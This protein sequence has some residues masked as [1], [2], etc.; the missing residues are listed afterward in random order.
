[1][2]STGAP[3]ARADFTWTVVGSQIY[4]WG[5]IGNSGQLS[6][7][8]VYDPSSNSWQTLLTT[9]SPGTRQFGSSQYTGPQTAAAIGNAFYVFGGF[10]GSTD[11][12]AGKCYSLGVL[13]APAITSLSPTTGSTLGGTSVAVNGSNFVSGATVTFDTTAVTASFVSSTQLTCTTPSHAAGAVNVTVTNPDTQTSTLSGGF[14]YISPPTISNIS[15]TSGSTTGGTSVTITGT[16]FQ[17]N[18][19][20]TFAGLAGTSGSADGD[21]SSA[22]FNGPCHICADSSGNLYV[23]DQSNNTIRMVTPSGQVSTIA[24]IL[25][26]KGSTDGASNI[27]TFNGPQGIAWTPNG[28][29]VADRYNQTIRLISAGMVSTLAGQAGTGGSRDGTGSSALFDN[30]TAVTVDASGMIFICDGFNAT[31]RT[32]TSAGVVTTIAGSPANRGSSDGT[33]SSAL[34][35]WPYGGVVS[36]GCFYVADCYNQSI[37]QVTYGGT[38][39]TFVGL[40][41]FANTGSADGTGTQ[42]RFNYPAGV[43]ADQS[44]NL[45]VTDNMNFTIRKITPSG[46]VT[47]IAG[48]AGTSGSADGNGSTARFNQPF[49]IAIDP[50]GKILYVSDRASNTIR[51]ISTPTVTFGG[52]AATNI[53]VISA[54]QITCTTSAHAAGAVDVVVTNADGQTAT[55]TG[56]Y[57]YVAAPAITSATSASGTVDTAFSY[58]ITASNWPTSY[59]AMGLPPWATVNTG[60]GA[61][62]GTPTTAGTTNI[63]IS[64]TNAGGT[65]TATLTITI[66]AQVQQAATPTFSPAAGTFTGA[67]SVTI[68]CSTSGATIYYTKDGST[69]TV[70]SPAYSGA[71]NVSATETLQAI[72]AAT[73]YVNSAVGSVAYTIVPPIAFTS[74]PAATPNPTGVEVGVS[75]SV[76]ASGG[77]GALT[78]SWTFG[79]GTAGTTGANTTHAYATSGSFTA[80]VTVTDALNDTNSANVTVTVNQEQ[81]A[82]PT[83]SPAAGTYSNALSI[84]I[85]CATSGASI[86]YTTDG[87]TPTAASTLYTAPINVTG[88]SNA[89]SSETT[90]LKAIAINAPMFNSGVASVTYT[91]GGGGANAPSIT[92]AL[93]ATATLGQAFSY[94]ITAYGSAP[95]T[96][97]AMNLPAGLAYSDGVISGTP[98]VAGVA[99]II[100]TAANAVGTDTETITLTINNPDSGGGGGSGTPVFSTLPTASPN[101]GIAGQ[102]VTFTAA[103]TDAAGDVLAFTW[104]FDDGNYGAGA[105]TTNT[106]ASSGLY[107]V[108]VTVTNGVANATSTIQLGINSPGGTTDPTQFQVQKAAITFKFSKTMQDSMTLTGTMP[109]PEGF[110]P[111]GQ[112]LSVVIG[113]YESDFTLDANGHATSTSGTDSIKL[114]G[115]LKN[116][117]YTVSPV[118]FLYTVKRQT[119]FP[120]LQDLGFDN[121]NVT[122]ADDDFVN[123]PVLF[124][125][126]NDFYLDTPTLSYTAKAGKTGS[127]K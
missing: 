123:V 106:Y 127:A 46:V 91:I 84:S 119:L 67:Q 30:P 98:M 73:G 89:S 31:I 109:V 103:A 41:G 54:T 40:T 34:F 6:D 26:V 42:A 114:A 71:I 3:A 126:E 15:P 76:A 49:G 18:F 108:T 125:V 70:S 80:T 8:F 21:G 102:V 121:D 120:S 1:M 45:Y 20:S 25:G 12:S 17:S 56:G 9:N 69:P 65:G 113:D 111:S 10:V 51:K 4:I 117:A 95:I 81:V 29:Y 97:N 22:S 52:A 112:T 74:G 87:S 7:G 39:T 86:Y 100:M 96:L 48:C 24:G 61:I 105:S 36:D 88:P 116:G 27:A 47:T 35:N 110:V 63:T 53:T 23:A 5:G 99:Q 77:S 75:F 2:S 58:T 11:V 62:S 82:T 122:K 101:P 92:S 115:V 93:S 68:S 28:L 118:K 38:V 43:A 104:D 79:D 50:T 37:R 13:P 60:T 72:A 83:F 57:T 107:T 32:C 33:G 55:S 90:T 59:N 19:V 66:N 124:T 16:G 78:Y 94:T 85:S 64:A 14:T 44:R